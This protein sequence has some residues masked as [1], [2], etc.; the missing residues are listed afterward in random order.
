MPVYLILRKSPKKQISMT[1]SLTT[2]LFWLLWMT[3]SYSTCKKLA[4]SWMKTKSY[5]FLD[6]QLYHKLLFCSWVRYVQCSWRINLC[7]HEVHA[8]L[9]R[10][11][12]LLW[13]QHQ[14]FQEIRGFPKRFL[15]FFYIFLSMVWGKKINWHTSRPS[16][17]DS[18]SKTKLVLWNLLTTDEMDI[19]TKA[20]IWDAVRPTQFS[21]PTFAPASNISCVTSVLPEKIASR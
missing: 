10:T 5:I 19:P 14:C 21:R 9:Q 6:K 8:D 3:Y 15:L 7:W 20:A 4:E 2:Q 1:V 12:S 16:H 11:G 17:L 13:K 18:C